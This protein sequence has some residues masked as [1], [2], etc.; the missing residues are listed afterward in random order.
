MRPFLLVVALIA[1]FPGAGRAQDVLPG[2]TPASDVSPMAPMGLETALAGLPRLVESTMVR[3][4]VPGMAVAVVREGEVVFRQGFG[5]RDIRLPDPVTPETVF[6]IASVSK[7]ISATVAAITISDGALHWDDPV[8][9]YLPDL[10]LSDSYVGAHATV[11]DFF[12]HRTGLPFAAGDDLEDIG[13][14]RDQILDRLGQLPLDPFRVTYHYANMGLTTGAEAVAAAAGRDWADL[15]QEK[16][17]GPLGMTATSYRHAD[18]MA[19]GN[20]AVLH[21]Y[22][23][24]MFQPLYDRDADAQAPAGGVSSTV[25]DLAKWMILLLADGQWQGMPLIDPAVLHP[26][27]RMQIVNSPGRGAN[28]RSGAY[29][30]GFNVETTAGGRP[31]RNHSGGFI[32]GAGTHFKLLTDAGIGIVVLSNGAPVGAV[33]SIAAEFMDVVQFGRSTRDWLTGYESLMAP[34]FDPVGDLVGQAAPQDP[35]PAG[36][37]SR[38]LGSYDNAYFGPAEVVEGP[39]GLA[40]LLGPRPLRLAL[41]PW[42]GDRFAVAPLGENQ[43][44]GSLSSVTFTIEG[45]LATALHVQYLDANGLAHWR[46]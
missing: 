41:Q 40:L 25:D 32:K 29:G 8:S 21:A 24:G 30:Y 28:D 18:A 20:R 6:Q 10:Q 27:M 7:S 43:P 42:D 23:H 11:G 4:G 3:S 36:P 9:D 15:A 12:A 45:D 19:A 2:P 16:L 44:L 17:F 1:A 38:Y 5:R 39:E 13:H 14:D 34:M 26:A 46:R 33:E 37:A 31:I 35:A 22:E